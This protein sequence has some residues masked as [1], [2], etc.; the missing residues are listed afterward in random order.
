M[1]V[2]Y[3]DVA[4]AGEL[5]HVYNEQLSGVPHCYP[6]SPEEFEIGIRYRK[7]ADEPYEELHSEKIIVCRQN[8]K[9]L[10]FADVALVETEADG[11]KKH[12]GLIRF[13]TYQPGYR[14]VGQVILTEA[15]RYLRD[16]GM[17]QITVF[18]I[19][20]DDDDFSYRFYQLGFGLV[21]D[22]M[23]HVYALFR[24]NGYEI[25][26]REQGE[27]FMDQPEYSVDEPVLPD[28]RV[29]I[30]VKQKPGRGILPG[31]TV[32]AFRSGREIGICKSFSVG[33][34]C[35]ASEAQD[36]CFIKWLG[37]EEEE[38]GKGWGR[39]LLQRNLWEMRKIGYKNTVIS[40]DIKNYRA[41]LFYTNYGYRVVNT[42]YGLVK[43][44]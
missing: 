19:A 25:N 26:R 42:G 4:N 3:W 34:Y 18:R 11:Q 8:G 17:N 24:M 38:R 36:W 1:Q 12:K 35:Q 41:Q 29:E 2:E 22:R 21:S 20:Y 7:D 39:Y 32:Q 9:I 14:P 15:E 28:S 37:V 43:N 30:V 40:A 6:V 27:I 23:G 44:I 16:L 5:V 31:L 10:G 13:L 33:R